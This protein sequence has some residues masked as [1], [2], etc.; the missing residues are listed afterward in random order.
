MNE[1]A[2]QAYVTMDKDFADDF[3]ERL[4][5]RLEH[6]TLL[7]LRSAIGDQPVLSGGEHAQHV[8]NALRAAGVFNRRAQAAML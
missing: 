6:E 1:A 8:T 2:L 5:S 3:R 4:A 7:R